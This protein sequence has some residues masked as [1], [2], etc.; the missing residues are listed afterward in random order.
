MGLLDDKL[1]SEKVRW[2]LEGKGLDYGSEKNMDYAADIISKEVERYEKIQ[3]KLR[4]ERIQKKDEAPDEKVLRELKSAM[5]L[6]AMYNL[7]EKKGKN[8]SNGSGVN[9][10]S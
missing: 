3:E 2:L 7:E 8:S 9:K 6:Q 4:I 10:S 1:P 5:L